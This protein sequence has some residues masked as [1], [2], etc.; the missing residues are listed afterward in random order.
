MKTVALGIMIEQIDG[1]RDT[2]ELTSWE[3]D[4]VA[5]IYERY[6]LAKKDTRNLSSKQV[7]VVARIWRKNFAG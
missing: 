6:L 4:F 7:E 5:S 1:M 3:N 2:K